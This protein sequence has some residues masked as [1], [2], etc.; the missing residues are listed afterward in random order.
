LGCAKKSTEYKIFFMRHHTCARLVIC[1][2]ICFFQNIKKEKKKRKE[3]IKQEIEH[4][5]AGETV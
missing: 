2:Y 3:K 4:D 1:N 5:T